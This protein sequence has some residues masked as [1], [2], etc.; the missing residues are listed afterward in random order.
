MKNFILC[1]AAATILA[2]CQ[3]HNQEPKK[4]PMMQP[5]QGCSTGGCMDA[6]KKAQQCQGI[7]PVMK[8]QLR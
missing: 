8:S 1:V 6:V 7:R 5:A 2:G 3:A 4:E